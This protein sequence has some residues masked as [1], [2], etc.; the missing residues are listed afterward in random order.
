ML[1]INTLNVTIVVVNLFTEVI[2]VK[3]LIA[4]SLIGGMLTTGA[5]AAPLYTYETKIP[6]AHSI[7][8]TRYENFYSDHNISYSVVR[9]D[10][11]DENTS[12]KLLKASQ[13][14]KLDTVINM[15]KA[16][17]NVVA[18]LNADFFS[19]APNGGA[20]SIGMEV[21]DGELI[22]SPINP[23]TM[24]TV[25]FDGESLAMSYLDFKITLTAPNGVSEAVTHLNKHTE[26]YGNILM[27]TSDF[28]GGYSPAPGGEVVEVV[29][30]QGKIMEFRRN[31]PPVEIPQDGCVFV[32]SE[33][34]SMYFANNF[35]VGDR[36]VVDCQAV[37][38]L[39][40][41]QSAFGG[42][43]LL[44]NEGE[45]IKDFSHTVSGYNPRS[46]LGVDKTGKIL[47]LV[48]VD[49][50]QDISRGMSMSELAWV[51]QS[52][53]CHYAINLDGGGSTNMVTWDMRGSNLTTANKPTENRKVINAVGITYDALPGKPFGIEIDGG[54]KLY[55]GGYI[56]VKATVYD[57]NMR[58]LDENIEWTST[59]GYVA[60]GY[61][62]GTE[63][64]LA[65]VTARCGGLTAE[66]QIF[67]SDAISGIEVEGYMQIK[68][69]TSQ[70]LS[71]K[72]FDSAGNVTLVSDAKEFK[73]KSSNPDVVVADG[74]DLK[75]IGKGRS[76]VSI[77]KDGAISYVSVFAGDEA[78]LKDALDAPS[79]YLPLPQNKYTDQ[80]FATGKGEI[81]RV[82]ALSSHSK[83]LMGEM[84]NAKMKETLGKA[85]ENCLIDPKAGFSAYEDNN[86][87]YLYL[88][89]SKGG[90]RATD[91]DQW[92]K[93]TEAVSASDKKDI[94]I[95]SDK[96]VF[97]ASDFENK[98]FKDYFSGLKGKNIWVIN[99]GNTNT[100][101]YEDGISYFTLANQQKEEFS[102]E[103]LK[104]YKYL[105]FTFGKT[106]GFEWKNL[107]E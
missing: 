75:A 52:L 4:L 40:N 79:V 82:G 14:D 97:G 61:F 77:E 74:F 63:P 83:T 65:V 39:E 41:I 12:F 72:V 76:I 96:S 17:D 16:E 80:S 99:R 22:Q 51:M 101:R 88:D 95:I 93:I 86:A 1:R 35:Q 91:G 30:S 57:E 55:K 69:G 47:Y 13:I 8:Y 20:L 81:F 43:A 28:N 73:V 33:G 31:M 67:V 11:N 26:Y 3:K 45:I 85:S 49:G 15:A 98:V 2:L 89:V 78:E 18:A 64:G 90:I 62:Y 34:V 7:D 54:D 46:A 102:A 106:T 36:V 32:V 60:D 27:Y 71:V 100:Y 25:L 103:Q 58:P 24:A 29:V 38:S 105:E 59:K 104:S 48:A 6:I 56:P 50:R 19:K 87:L 23:D 5:F 84:V 107:Y 37:P 68:E 44:V 70:K 42:G 66:K 53:G 21:K 94:F 9:V 10:L 92:N